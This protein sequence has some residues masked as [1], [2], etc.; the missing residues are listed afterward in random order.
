MIGEIDGLSHRVFQSVRRDRGEV[1]DV[2]LGG[3]L[4][5]PTGAIFPITERNPGYS[6]GAGWSRRESRGLS[7]AI[8]EAP[9]PKILGLERYRIFERLGRGQIAGDKVYDPLIQKFKELQIVVNDRGGTTRSKC[10][11][12][13]VGASF[14]PSHGV[15]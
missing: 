4:P 3:A 6:A 5:V 14:A 12:N 8:L 1:V 7:A 2:D 13:R 10:W 9:G 15:Y 11:P